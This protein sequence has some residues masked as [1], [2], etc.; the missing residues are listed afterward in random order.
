MDNLASEHG[1]TYYGSMCLPRPIVSIMQRDHTPLSRTRQTSPVAIRSLSFLCSVK[2]LHN[3]RHSLSSLEFPRSLLASNFCSC[4]VPF[5]ALVSSRAGSLKPEIRLAQAVS[6][7][8]AS[9][10]DTQKVAFRN[11]R[12]QSLSSPP[13]TK[14]VM[15]ITAEID[16]SQKAGGRCFGPRFTKFLHGVQQ[17]AALG[18]I[19]VGGSQNLIACGVWTVVRTCLLVRPSMIV[20]I[21][22]T[23][24]C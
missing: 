20:F 8:E 3:T 12:A 21:Q 19:L 7:F 5:M 10:S 15:R 17:F 18:D 22:I 1:G 24:Y 4:L 13:S 16:V 9:L 14:D 23:V 2:A 6:Q 11:Q